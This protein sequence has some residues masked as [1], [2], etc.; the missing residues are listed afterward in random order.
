MARGFKRRAS[1]LIR[2][3]VADVDLPVQATSHHGLELGHETHLTAQQA[4]L[5][6]ASGTPRDLQHICDVSII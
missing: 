2:V 3:H 4:R 5:K 1:G 6:R